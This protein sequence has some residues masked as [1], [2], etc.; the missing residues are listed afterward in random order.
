MPRR[1]NLPKK[2][3]IS[4]ERYRELYYFCLQYE[5]KKSRANDT[6]FL[7]ASGTSG[8]GKGFNSSSPTE[9]SAESAI[10]DKR[11]VEL[12]EKCIRLACGDDAGLYESLL[13][14]ITKGIPPERMNTP[15]GRRQFYERRSNFYFL[16]DK[17]KR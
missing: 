9:R 13:M 4:S 1:M 8:G 17:E 2:Y 10:N 16:L 5:E 6:Y 3:R 14:N 7:K 11:D 15:I 12:I